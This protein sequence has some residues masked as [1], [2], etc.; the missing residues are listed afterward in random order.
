[1]RVLFWSSPSAEIVV[2]RAGTLGISPTGGERWRYVSDRYMHSS[3]HGELGTVV[4]VETDGIDS[5]PDAPTLLVR[6]G[7]TKLLL[8]HLPLDRVTL[9]SREER[10]AISNVD[11]ADFGARLTDDGRVELR[12]VR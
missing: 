9:V 12:L 8:Y 1:M 2:G 4:M 6:G 11:V 7:S 3:R 5:A 10:L